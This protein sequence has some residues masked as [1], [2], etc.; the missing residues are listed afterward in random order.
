MHCC[1]SI[2]KHSIFIILLTL[3]YVCQQY[4]G[5]AVMIFRSNDGYANAQQWY[6]TRTLP[7]LLFFRYTASMVGGL[8]NDAMESIWKETDVAWSR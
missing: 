8:V 2:T 3:T 6:V 7:I 4:K 1:V 5:N